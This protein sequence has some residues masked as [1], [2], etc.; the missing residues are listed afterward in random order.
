MPVVVVVNSHAVLTFSSLLLLLL[1][2]C[3]ETELNGS[4]M[5]GGEGRRL[6]FMPP[7][8]CYKV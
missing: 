8:K 1:P 3:D 2:I 6:L 7:L 5:G 4:R